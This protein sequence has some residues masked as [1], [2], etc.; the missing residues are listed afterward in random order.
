MEALHPMNSLRIL[1][2]MSL[3]L[4]APV[5][6]A[7]AQVGRSSTPAV[8]S[9]PPA[10]QSPRLASLAS[11]LEAGDRSALD[12]FWNEIN[13]NAPLVEPAGDDYRYRWVTFVWRGS[14]K[15]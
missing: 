9:A 6:S 3:L 7:W 15:T 8:G 2:L 13:G 5:P 14:S 12:R 10:Y 11:E 4:N 1:I